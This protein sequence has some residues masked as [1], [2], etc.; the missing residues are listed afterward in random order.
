MEIGRMYVWHL[1]AVNIKLTILL[2]I[3]PHR[4]VQ[5]TVDKSKNT[6]P[7]FLGP[8]PNVTV[9]VGRDAVL[10]CV[11]KNLQDYKV[12]F[13]HLDRQMIVTIHNH[14]ITRIP[15]FEIHHDKHHTWNLHIR[16]VQ[17]EDQGHYMCQ[18][19]TDPML[20]KVGH[21]NV[22]VPPNIVDLES[23]PSAVSVRE[24]HNASLVCK[25]EGTPEPSIKW[26][27]EDK[28][29]IIIKRKKKEGKKEK[30]EVH[31]EVLDL[32]RISRTEMGA[33]L[34]IAQNGVPP[35]ISKRII[36]TVEFS[37]MIWIPNQLV[38]AP[39]G[40]SVKLVCHTES[41][42]VA[43]SYWAFNDTMVLT[44]ERFS[45]VERHHS[46]YMLD[47]TLFI[48]ELKKKDF[49]SY[50]CISKNS[51]GESDGAIMLYELESA[52]TKVSTVATYQPGMI[53]ITL[54]A[55][56]GLMVDN[57]PI[58]F[59]DYD[60]VYDYHAVSNREQGNEILPTG[61]NQGFDISMNGNLIGDEAKEEVNQDSSS[62]R[63]KSSKWPY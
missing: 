51:L 20:S 54:H 22:V 39:M 59:L 14:V 35:S 42:P 19:N 10:A 49:G 52:T 37:P 9:A 45:T 46:E 17:K 55:S 1:T 33:Y 48:K 29:P 44:S 32:I 6:H 5:G 30:K 57:E 31:G 8:I 40:T 16:N 11:V 53:F 60:S 56:R 27:R 50:R 28:R 43:I 18:I 24:N 13:I 63:R 3:L 61:L 62:K 47:S 34:C 7:E 12:A 58:D 36:L 25:A 15:R 23:S 41:S 26:Q 21:L 38:G 2:I 4:G